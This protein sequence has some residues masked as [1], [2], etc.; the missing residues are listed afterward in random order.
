MRKDDF[1]SQIQNDDFHL[2]KRLHSILSSI[3]RAIV[4]IREKNTLLDE[5]CKII[6]EKGNYDLVWI[7]LKVEDEE[8]YNISSS[9]LNREHSPIDLYELSNGISENK[10]EET[11]LRRNGYSV[12]NNLHKEI[13]NAGI[14]GST[15]ITI[16]SSLYTFPI[17]I[18]NKFE[19]KLRL[20]S[21]YHRP[22]K[23]EELNLLKEISIDVAFALERIKLE[24][25]TILS[26]NKL[27]EVIENSTNLFYSHDINFLLTYVS[28]R[29]MEFLGYTPEESGVNWTKFLTDNPI[30]QIGIKRTID[31]IKTGEKQEPYELELKTKDGNIVWVLVNETPVVKNGKTVSI[32]GSLTNITERKKVTIERDNFFKFSNDIMCV[33][34]LEGNFLASN[35]AWEN[36]LGYSNEELTKLKVVDLTHSDDTHLLAEVRDKAKQGIT[37]SNFLLRA[38]C[39][40]NSL[41]WLSWNSFIIGNNIY[42]LGRDVTELIETETKLKE[43]LRNQG[44][45]NKE[46]ARLSRA[47]EQSPVSIVLTDLNGNI[48]YANPKCLEITG[49]SL[50]EVIGQNPRVFKSGEKDSIE[51]KDLWQSISS[52]KEWKGEFHNKKKSGELFWELASISPVKNKDGEIISY[53]AV[54]EDITERKSMVD[55]LITA[56]EEAEE[57]NR[58]KSNFFSNMS[59]EL[60]TPLV[61]IIGYS[62]MLL[63]EI[64]NNNQK[65]FVKSILE[66]G[67]RLL[68]TLN[69]I[70]NISR[71]EAEKVK[72]QLQMLNICDEVTYAVDSNQNSALSKKLNLTV[73]DCDKE[74]YC[75]IDK[76]IFRVIINSIINNAIKYTDNGSVSVSI[77]SKLKES[78]EFVVIDISDTGI[79]ISPEN[80][81]IIFEEFRQGSEGLSRSFEGVGLGLT[82]AQK[83]VRLLNGDIA[84]SSEL[85]KGSVFSIELPLIASKNQNSIYIHPQNISNS[86]AVNRYK[87]PNILLVED[88]SVNRSVAEYFLKDVGELDIVNS[89]ESALEK[90]RT[91]QYNLILMDIALGAGM[92]GLETTKLIREINNYKSIPI[93]ALTA[94]AM[95]IEKDKFLV[96]GCNDYL[97]KPFTKEE[98]I[99]KVSQA[100]EFSK[101]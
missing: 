40:D 45:T 33:V 53:L 32:V 101:N 59:H 9:Y 85:G 87:K 1:K 15:L 43:A 52:G 6:T 70:L 90:V 73:S 48:E 3:N 13:I 28:P 91:K 100:I 54:K 4:R 63:D 7:E 65:E 20:I 38:R 67:N 64:K 96:G 25:K 62:E 56:K 41:K 42:A 35:Q 80:Y 78:K 29:S 27:R 11:I 68:K 55:E 83:Y 23:D 46:L 77:R 74:I 51:Y 66:S 36:L 58:I 19:G 60:R 16:S 95:S 92:N 8:K 18:E 88:D 39:K 99:N 94:Y 17:I 49:Y 22:I 30:N 26:E 71:L 14:F 79:G 76:K 21:N 50:E 24:E 61:G 93:I 10:D 47:V 69:T 31:A 72:P 57:I 5:V 86:S 37:S 34:D 44:K 84:V 81:K 2:M 82:I 89:G 97:S 98:L 75:E 12:K